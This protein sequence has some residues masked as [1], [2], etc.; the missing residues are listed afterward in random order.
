MTILRKFSVTTGFV[1]AALILAGA[2]TEVQAQQYQRYE[3]PVIYNPARNQFVVEGGYAGPLGDLEADYFSTDQGIGA[4]GGYSVGLRFRHYLTPYLAVAPSFQYVKF[5]SNSGVADFPGYGDNLA[6]SID[7]SLFRYAIDLQSFLGHI[8]NR[9]RPFITLGIS[10]NHNRYHDEIQGYY[11]YDHATDTLA[12]AL[13][14]GLQMGAV[15][16][17]AVYNYNRF[18]TNGLPS[19]TGNQDYDWDYFVVGAG[20]GFGRF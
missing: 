8:R 14:V 17:T 7:T 20:I 18:S 6:Y 2:V 13:G 9:V 5:G 10:L 19:A 12:G 16:L 3:K 4:S 15:E 1:M 11:P